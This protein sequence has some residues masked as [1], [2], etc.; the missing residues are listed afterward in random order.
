MVTFTLSARQIS[1]LSF[2]PPPEGRA[3]I[4]VTSERPVRVFV[5]DDKNLANLVAHQPFRPFGLDIAQPQKPIDAIVYLPRWEFHVAFSNR[6]PEP[7]EVQCRVF[8]AERW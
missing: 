4:R 1:H 5:V 6:N 3:L 2:P 7:C 8:V